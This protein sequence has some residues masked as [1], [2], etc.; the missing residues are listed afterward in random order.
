MKGRRGFD[1]TAH[2][3]NVDRWCSIAVSSMVCCDVFL[4]VLV[5]LSHSRWLTRQLTLY[6]SVFVCAAGQS[7]AGQLATVSGTATRSVSLVA[8]FGR[9]PAVAGSVV[10]CWLGIVLHKAGCLLVR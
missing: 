1:C 2:G 7:M 10:A 4:A 3:L 9:L 5:F 6:A 8:Q